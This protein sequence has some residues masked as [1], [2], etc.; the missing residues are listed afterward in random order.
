[1]SNY[2]PL[3]YTEEVTNVKELLKSQVCSGLHI[4]SLDQLGHRGLHNYDIPF[5][6]K[7]LDFSKFDSCHK[8]GHWSSHGW[9]IRDIAS[10]FGLTD[11]QISGIVTDNA[12]NVSCVEHLN[13]PL[14]RCFAHILQLSIRKGFD[15]VD[16]I[17]KKVAA[18][19]K[20]CQSRKE[21]CYYHQWVA[22]TS[23]PD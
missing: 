22:C 23:K 1:M 19:R 9:K 18:S 4:W 17:S 7:G 20:T 6:W 10:E 11:N 8:E 15:T 14:I 5:R 3:Q 21:V 12:S 13:W 2:V 16:A